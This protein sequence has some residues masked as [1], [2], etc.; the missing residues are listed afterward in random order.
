MIHDGGYMEISITVTTSCNLNCSYC[1]QGTHD[2]C[3]N[4]TED[5]AF[6]IANTIIH[7]LEMSGDK[8]LNI[9][10]IGGEAI[11]RF[12]I[13]E[14]FVNLMNEKLS[15][16]DGTIK[17]SITTNGTIINNHII[18][19]L[20]KNKF[21]VSISIDGDQESHDKNRIDRNSNGTYERAMN[22]A[23]KLNNSNIDSTIRM[24]IAPESAH[25][26]CDNII[27]LYNNGFKIIAPVCDY[28]A[29][30]NDQQIIDLF[31]NYVSLGNWYLDLT[32]EISIS[33]F[34]GRFYSLLTRKGL[35]CKAGLGDHYIF[36]VDGTIFPCNYVSGKN[37]FMLGNLNSQ[38]SYN[39]K[40]EIYRKYVSSNPDSECTN[41]EAKLFCH[42]RKCGFLNYIS[43]GYLNTVMPFLCK[44]ERF[45]FSFLCEMIVKI[46]TSRYHEIKDLFEYIRMNHLGNESF[47]KLSE[48]IREINADE[49]RLII[50]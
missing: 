46:G 8:Q 14:Y 25:K 47:D 34:D 32:G 5:K 39:E 9:L 20:Q 7:S 17:Y 31:N 3:S 42:G 16:W 48:R 30:W 2:T 12:R 6:K 43:T 19:F 41:C 11:I 10:F 50:S 44:H 23:I 37:E 1:Y 45:M 26:L 29:D 27:H 4:L 15:N 13:I 33:C 35:F 21:D 49:N 22:N 36:A 24:T 18:E 38:K 40:M 28:L